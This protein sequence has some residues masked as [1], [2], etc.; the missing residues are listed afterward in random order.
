MA[1]FKPEF[2]KLRL[3]YG[4]LSLQIAII[5]GEVYLS[6]RNRGNLDS[7]FGLQFLLLKHQK[8][9]GENFSVDK[10]KKDRM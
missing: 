10:I 2:Q 3:K 9:H 8:C 6:D 4:G 7:H 5:F 1:K